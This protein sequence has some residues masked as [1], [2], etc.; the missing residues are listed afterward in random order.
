MSACCFGI[1]AWRCICTEQVCPT[2]AAAQH[3]NTT[4]A[5]SQTRTFSG[6]QS[7]C[8]YCSGCL[9]CHVCMF[10]EL[11]HILLRH[12]QSLTANTT[13]R[14]PLMWLHQRFNLIYINE[15]LRVKRGRRLFTCWTRLDMLFVQTQGRVKKAEMQELL[16]HSYSHCS[17]TINATFQTFQ[18]SHLSKDFC[19]SLY[20]GV[21]LSSD[22]SILT[23]AAS[24]FS[25]GC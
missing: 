1:H 21:S 4:P 24:H 18:T 22:S 7:E 3:H 15:V 8:V 10:S 11:C 13:N 19:N 20:T 9:R 16:L 23:L 25:N 12:K 17:F 6:S 2:W 5:T 14:V